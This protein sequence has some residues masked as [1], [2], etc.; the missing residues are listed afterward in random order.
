[1]NYKLSNFKCGAFSGKEAERT[2]GL[3]EK[4]D[5]GFWAFEGYWLQAIFQ[6]QMLTHTE[7]ERV[8]YLG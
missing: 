5:R 4:L 6:G 7:G 3:T 1:M 2:S 8:V